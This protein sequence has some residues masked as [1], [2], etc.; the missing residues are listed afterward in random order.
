M[1]LFIELFLMVLGSPRE[2]PTQPDPVWVGLE[3]MVKAARLER[4]RL[5]AIYLTGFY[6][7]ALNPG[8]CSAEAWEIVSL[9]Q[10]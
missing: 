5:K 7:G 3:P 1:F 2:E 4:C 9:L 8:Q 10:R 6:I